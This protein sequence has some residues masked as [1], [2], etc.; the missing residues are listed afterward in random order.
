MAL[1]T[2]IMVGAARSLSGRSREHIDATCLLLWRALL[3]NRKTILLGAPVI[4]ELHRRGDGPPGY[5]DR[6]EPGALD[7]VAAKMLGTAFPASVLKEWRDKSGGAPL[8]YIKFDAMVVACAVR[9]KATMFVST[10]DNQLSMA[11][12]MGL[13][14]RRPE[15]LLTRQ[16]EMYQEQSAT[17]PPKSTPAPPASES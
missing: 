1:D 13:D 11:A 8:A 6:I 14:A 9:H 5:V 15:S 7:A 17:Y 4:A 2:S 10:D 16:V 12:S 3:E